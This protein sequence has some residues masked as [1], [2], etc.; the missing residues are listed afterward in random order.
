[1]KRGAASTTSRRG[2]RWRRC[3]SCGV[4]ERASDFAAL[5]YR[6]PWQDG[7][8]SR[9]CPNCG[10]VAATWRFQAVRERHP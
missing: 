2:W 1:M 6:E 5:E 7:G 9:R 4:V 3:P 8:I 10:H